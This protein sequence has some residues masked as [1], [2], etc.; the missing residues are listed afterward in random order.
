MY[1]ICDTSIL[2]EF[3]Y[4]DNLV[5]E[6]FEITPWPRTFTRLT[7]WELCAT[8]AEIWLVPLTNCCISLIR[9]L[10]WPCFSGT[11]EKLLLK[12]D[13]YQRATSFT[14]SHPESETPPWLIFLLDNLMETRDMF[15]RD[16]HY[17][18]SHL[19]ILM[20][21]KGKLSIYTVPNQNIQSCHHTV[22]S[23]EHAHVIQFALQLGRE[24]SQD[25]TA[26]SWYVRLLLTKPSL[27]VDS[28]YSRFLPRML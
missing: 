24:S 16:E 6:S 26:S 22:T 27:S 23:H 28:P 20:Y 13:S 9:I 19:N 21:W 15:T 1:Q 11:I 17:D 14:S 10:Y 7:C 2:P 5:L 3:D 8:P 18:A 25:T 12:S 4:Y